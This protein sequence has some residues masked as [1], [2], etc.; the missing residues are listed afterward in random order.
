[1]TVQVNT[2]LIQAWL[3]SDHDIVICIL[4]RASSISSL[5][6]YPA[7]KV[8]SQKSE[9][10]TPQPSSRMTSPSESHS[11]QSSSSNLSGGRIA[12]LT[13][14]TVL[15]VGL[16]CLLL[17]YPQLV[18][19]RLVR[20][21][22][23]G[24][25]SGSGEVP[26]QEIPP[27]RPGRASGNDRSRNEADDAGSRRRHPKDVNDGNTQ[28][29]SNE[30][31]VSRRSGSPVVINNNIYINSGDYLQPLPAL[32]SQRN[33]DPALTGVKIS[34]NAQ[35]A[36]GIQNLPFDPRVN[37]DIPPQ[38][39]RND[40]Y[41]ASPLVA[42]R[43]E[44]MATSNFWDV[45]DWAR[46]VASGQFPRSPA[47][48][49]AGSPILE[50]QQSP[51]SRHQGST[52]QVRAFDVPGAF[53]EDEDV[54]ERFQLVTAPARAHAPRAPSHGDN[55]FWVREARESRWRRQEQEDRRD[56]QEKEDRRERQE[57][58]ERRERDRYEREERRER[59]RLERE[60]RRERQERKERGEMQEREDMRERHDELRRWRIIY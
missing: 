11:S 57:R 22:S 59:A 40:E 7:L 58:E 52:T 8:A 37:L 16:V 43:S 54:M 6:S 29:Q 28:P 35:G 42:N 38:R 46:G 49:S 55:G 1:M 51:V 27:Q 56:R 34:R 60:E 21:R 5:C 13:I 10:A 32:N 31:V 23:R 33:R 47:R 17:S 9:M 30:I 20:S 45:A 53:P 24:R 44:Q 4:S 39:R 25:S 18:L 15:A 19:T 50:A 3:K 14:G 12:A 48:G 36:S 2:M 26:L 41:P